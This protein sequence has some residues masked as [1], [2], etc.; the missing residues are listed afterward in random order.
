MNAPSVTRPRRGLL[1]NEPIILLALVLAGLYVAREVLIPLAMALTLNFLLTPLVMVFERM[2]V[3]R[4]PAVFLVLIM[5]SGVVG[6]VGWIVTRQLLGM[7]NDLPNYSD[8]IRAKMASLHAPAGGE[9][10]QTLGSLRILGDAFTDESTTPAP[11]P[12]APQTSTLVHGRRAREREAAKLQ[13][14]NNGQPT[15]V[16]VIPQSES[17]RPSRNLSARW[18]WCSS[19]PCTCCSSARICATA[20]CCWPGWG[21]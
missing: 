1:T 7:I 13:A 15:P 12:A 19:S 2:R 20:C 6:G 17:T 9:L 11:T 21:G 18:A 5:A 14:E 3:R 4:V 16:V 8:N 10:S